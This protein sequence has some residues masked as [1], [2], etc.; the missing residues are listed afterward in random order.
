M[1]NVNESIQF[2]LKQEDSR[3]SGV[4]TD[5][6]S[7]KGGRTRFGVAEK[8][9]PKLT[10]TGFYDTMPFDTAL[11]LATEVYTKEYAEPLQLD[12]I[13]S[14]EVA[15]AAL[16]FDVNEGVGTFVKLLQKAL[17][18]VQDGKFGPITLVK[19]N[20]SVPLTLLRAL[21]VV[22]TLYYQ[23]IVHKDPTQQKFYKGWMNR[24]YQDCNP[25]SLTMQG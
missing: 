11:A 15:N 8:A 1:A 3:L 6:A 2:V 19:V 17:G 14:Q 23:D 21:Q 25:P 20:S 22:E 13:M 4:I 9:H 16:S 24:I 10:S 12:K 5:T 18:L 7:D